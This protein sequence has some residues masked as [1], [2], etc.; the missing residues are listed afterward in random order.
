MDEVPDQGLIDRHNWQIFPLLKKRYLFSEVD[1]FYLYDFYN[2]D[3]LVDE[4]VYAYSNRSGNERALVLYY[5]RFGDTAG[6]VR[7]S[8]AFRDK[9]SDELRQV[10]LRI[11]LDLPASR[12]H[13]VI[14]RDSITGLEYIRSCA[15]IA[16]KGLYVQLDAYRA[17]VF[18]DFRVIEDDVENN[19][20]RVHDY[21]KGRGAPDIQ[22]LRWELPLQPV[23]QPLRE[24]FNP[25]Y[26][27][28]LIKSLPQTAGGSLPEFLLNEAEYK[29]DELVKGAR[30]MLP[31]TEQEANPERNFKRRLNALCDTLWIDQNL[32]LQE[33]SAAC[34]ALTVV[35][36]ELG[37]QNALVLLAW[38]YLEGLRDAL[39]MDK[40]RFGQLVEDWRFMP[41][42]EGAM[43]GMGIAA[44]SPLETTESVRL[45]LNLQGWLKR[46]GK[47]IVDKLTSEL[48]ENEDI[49]HYLQFNIYAGKHWFNREAFESFWF[50]LSMEGV[51]E[52][53]AVR[54]LSEKQLRTRLEQLA[55]VLNSLRTAAFQAHFEEESWL[56][57]LRRPSAQA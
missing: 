34:Q 41:V 1:R 21:L 44:L 17:H 48:L 30:A 54:Q 38:V 13:Y 12:S 28:F 32:A 4:N 6:W 50:Y 49:R 51:F 16:Q 35:R 19:W 33:D 46:L 27:S 45:L 36:G 40:E 22:Q 55:V 9:A 23:L 29:L 57:L 10:D 56:D 42:L 15:E 14:F 18:L 24:I 2:Q 25:G 7:T 3:G 53:L 31:E 11:G 5:N 8:A 26:F 47:R 43:R 37:D 39:G 52:L 20:K